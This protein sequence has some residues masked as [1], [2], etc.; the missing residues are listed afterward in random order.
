MSLPFRHELRVRFADT[1]AQG[2]VFFANHL[3]YFDEAMSA[4]FRAQGLPYSQ[5][6][7]LGVDLVYV[8]ANAQYA[9]PARFEEV[10]QVELTELKVGNTSVTF[11]L[12][13]T[14]RGG[15]KLCEGTLVS[16]CLDLATHA[17]TSLPE[18]LRAL[19]NGF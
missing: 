5:L 17:P 6:K 7:K 16:V 11:K 18:R 19:L 13:T 4:F 2:H 14:N 1:D 12:Q 3:T 9:A 10:L 15:Q 8:N